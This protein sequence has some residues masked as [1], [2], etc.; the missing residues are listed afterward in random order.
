[1]QGEDFEEAFHRQGIKM[2][3]YW[4]KVGDPVIVTQNSYEHD[5]YNGNTGIMEDLVEEE[6]QLVAKF[7]FA[8]RL[9]EFN[10][11]DLWTLG[12]QLAYAITVHKSQGSEYNETIICSIVQSKFIERSMIYTALTKSKKLCLIVGDQDI[13]RAAVAKP[14]RSETLC[15]GFN[16]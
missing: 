16:L 7:S 3:A 13:A 14:N 4:I 11:S 15:V 1:M 12:I 5:L 9:Y 8:E 10:C 2:G 6:G